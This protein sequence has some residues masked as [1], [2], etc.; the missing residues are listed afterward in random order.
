MRTPSFTQQAKGKRLKG[1]LKDQPLSIKM[2]TLNG[3]RGKNEAQNKE[4]GKGF[5]NR[6]M[7]SGFSFCYREKRSQLLMK[8]RLQKPWGKEA[9]RRTKMGFLLELRAK[10]ELGSSSMR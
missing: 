4:R 9:K 2:A 1:G 10:R 8:Q 3:N 6:E 5:L 7:G